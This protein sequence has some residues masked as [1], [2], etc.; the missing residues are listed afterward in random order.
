VDDLCGLVEE[1]FAAAIKK[2]AGIV[3]EKTPPV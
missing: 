1:T 2:R 3:E